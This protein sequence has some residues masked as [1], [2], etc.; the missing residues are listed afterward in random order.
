MIVHLKDRKA[1]AVICGIEQNIGTPLN[2]RLVKQ[3][4]VRMEAS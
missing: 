4:H 2:S 1:G 3:R